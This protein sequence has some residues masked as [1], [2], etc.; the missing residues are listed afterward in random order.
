MRLA[1]INGSLT[2]VRSIVVFRSVCQAS[3]TE[4]KY[5]RVLILK[6]LDTEDLSLTDQS[7]KYLM[8]QKP[9]G[10]KGR[11][12]SASYVASPSAVP[13]GRSS[14]MRHVEQQKPVRWIRWE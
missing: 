6:H 3:F 5:I 4:F 14:S 11:T 13:E 8:E 10:G 2:Q 1:T 7:C 9:S 12:S